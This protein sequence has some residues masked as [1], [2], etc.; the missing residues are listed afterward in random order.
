[1]LL[2]V[3]SDQTFSINSS[4]FPAVWFREGRCTAQWEGQTGGLAQPL[5]EAG[6]GPCCPSSLIHILEQK[7][8]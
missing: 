4:P 2:C 6:R 5:P 3:V 1:M 7:P 8:P